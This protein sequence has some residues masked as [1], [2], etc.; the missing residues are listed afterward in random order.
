[1]SIHNLNKKQEFSKNIQD[2]D[3]IIC[4]FYLLLL[5]LI[6]GKGIIMT[7]APIVDV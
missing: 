4:L 7:F 6:M 3:I 2:Y 1:M 5:Y